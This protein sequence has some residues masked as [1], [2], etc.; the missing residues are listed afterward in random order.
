M[1]KSYPLLLWKYISDQAKVSSLVEIV[2]H[3]NLE[4]YSLKRQEQVGDFF[5]VISDFPCFWKNWL[6]FAFQNFKNLLQLMKD[7]FFKHGDKDPLRACMKAIN[8]C[9]ME[10][11]GELQDFVRIKLK[12][13]EDEIIAKLKS[14][15]KEVVVCSMQLKF[16][17]FCYFSFL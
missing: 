16:H 4:Y 3:M 8:F 14:A 17:N 6:V 5:C 15:I 13:L 11:Q 12:E 7:A 10:S 9:C 1:M 2:L